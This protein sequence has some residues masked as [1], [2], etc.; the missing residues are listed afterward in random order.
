MRL[1]LSLLRLLRFLTLALRV[2]LLG[3]VAFCIEKSFSLSFPS[4]LNEEFDGDYVCN[5]GTEC[6]YVGDL[7]L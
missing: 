7:T 1:F 2:S 3:L 6:L 4:V 5:D